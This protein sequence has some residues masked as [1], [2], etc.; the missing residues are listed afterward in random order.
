MMIVVAIIGI[1]TAISIVSYQ[2]QVRKTDF[3][4]IYQTLNEFRMP[5]QILINEEEGVASF[6]STGLNMPAQTKYCQFSV[7]PPNANAATPNAVQCQIQ[8]LSYLSNQ[9]LS[10]DRAADGSWT[11]RASTGIA[12]AY[13]PQACR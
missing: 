2:V 6:S 1:L 9:T 10:L 11:C 4:T 13:L 5:Y 3:I 8:N 12:H 7:T